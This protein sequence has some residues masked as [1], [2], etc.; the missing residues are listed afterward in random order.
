MKAAAIG[1]ATKDEQADYLLSNLGD[2]LEI[3]GSVI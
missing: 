3:S 1:D 2:L